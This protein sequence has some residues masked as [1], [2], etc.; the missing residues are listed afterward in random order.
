MNKFNCFNNLLMNRYAALK[1]AQAMPNSNLINLFNA[2]TNKK[3]GIL[4]SMC[5]EGML[6]SD[7]A[8]FKVVRKIGQGNQNK[9]DI[10]PG[11]A[12]MPDG[13]IAI[14]KKLT[15]VVIPPQT[16]GHGV[17]YLYVE[18]DIEYRMTGEEVVLHGHSHP[19]V[20]TLEIDSCKFV[21]SQEED[22]N[23]IML[24]QIYWTQ[25]GAALSVPGHEA[26]HETV[27][28]IPDDAVVY[29]NIESIDWSGAA[30]LQADPN[31]INFPHVCI[32]NECM[33]K[34]ANNKWARGV[35][36]TTARTYHGDNDF[37]Y[38]MVW[39][40]ILDMRQRNAL[41][42]DIKTAMQDRRDDGVALVGDEYKH[43]EVTTKKE[44]PSIPET[45]KSENEIIWLNSHL[46]AG[47]LTADM[48]AAYEEVQGVQ[49]SINNTLA[50]I[51]KAKEDYAEAG[52]STETKDRLEKELHRHQMALLDY[53][54]RAANIKSTLATRTMDNLRNIDMRS[55]A[56]G[57]YINEPEHNDDIDEPIMYE[58]EVYYGV[59]DSP[60]NTP[61]TGLPRWFY[62][63]R[64][65]VEDINWKTMERTYEDKQRESG[66]YNIIYVPIRFGERIQY[67]VRSIGES[68]RVSKYSA[69][70]TFM[71]TGY[72]ASQQYVM[73]N[74]IYNV[75]YP[76]P[77]QEG[78]ITREL[79]DLLYSV[80]DEYRDKT[81]RIVALEENVQ[82]L[83]TETAL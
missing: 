68:G 77:Y 47:Y 14:N 12:I 49:E 17:L 83:I 69:K 3:N 79:V 42:L 7:D 43:I 33:T 56:Y 11:L 50:M 16:E 64:R 40:P 55:F 52:N 28:T 80:I 66:V 75:L 76:D 8:S 32:N 22:T 30:T 25:D 53:R 61:A 70:E 58:A 81:N 5:T 35:F 38:N 34:I 31:F 45:R 62:S 46:A 73:V 82:V 37:S 29:P 1:Y 41:R 51:N 59:A 60:A 15:T 72:K 24:A 54:M 39:S 78:I 2:S 44:L 23:K 71:F 18:H 63:R 67:R 13:N 27:V 20:A 36:G 9:I 48:V 26:H 4:T 19:T 74:N 10:H 57:I 65:N 6:P 21:L